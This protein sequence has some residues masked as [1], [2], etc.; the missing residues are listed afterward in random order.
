MVKTLP[1]QEL[2]RSD[3]AELLK[4]VDSLLW[5]LVYRPVVDLVRPTLPKPAAAALAPRAMRDA[6]PREL[7]NAVEDEGRAAL[8][9]G[10]KDG[11]VQRVPDHTGQ[12]ALFA[13]VRPD[14]RVSDGLKS[15]G[16]A[17]N[18]TTGLWAC[19]P[20]QVPAWVRLEADGYV[21]KARA[22][23]D[24]IKS[25]LDQL[26]GKVD[27]A[28]N[29]ADLLQAAKHATGEIEDGWKKAAKQL[30]VIPDLGAAGQDA[31]AAA[32]AAKAKIPIVG[33]AKEMIDQ[34][35]EQVDK[36]ALQGYRSAGLAMRIRDQYAI[37]KGRADLIARQETN[38][39]MA[40]YRAARA[41]DAGLRRYVW[42]IADRSQR[43]RLG[44]LEINGRIFSYV[45]KA[46]ARYM[47]CGERCNPGE[48]FRCRCVD[49][50][51]IE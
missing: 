27:R 40:G 8:R 37:A 38:N 32:F 12:Y 23:H 14:R 51:V 19:A 20:A 5:E 22:T 42:T 28:V 47:S 35:R 39:F 45:T 43:T 10:L 24:Q 15:F 30:E 50:P 21:A 9:R 1:G 13:V 36:N 4:S 44:H 46:P 7:R 48:D 3:Y 31:L 6:S 26:E 49:R 17:L 29:A 2:T 11:S 34:L 16:C 25:L 33:M 41:L 18:K